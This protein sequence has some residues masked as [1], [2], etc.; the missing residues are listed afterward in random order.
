MINSIKK[1]SKTFLFKVLVGIIILPFLFWGM[2]DVFSG[3]SQ[4]VVA[5]IDSEK[6]STRDFVNYL[7]VLD[8]NEQERRNLPNSDL[9]NRILSDYIGKKV[10]VLEL[11]DLDVI[12]EDSSLK[13]LILND[14]TFFKN[15]KFSRTEY[16]KFLISSSIS[17]PLFETN[18]AEQEK[19]D[20]Y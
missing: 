4:N 14:K 18:L 15:N 7:N 3:G 9:I 12:L 17:A 19:K 6:I 2:G 11:E 5:K 1:Y 10:L 20:N 13:E 16:E 8:L